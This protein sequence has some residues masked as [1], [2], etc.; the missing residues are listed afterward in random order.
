M[1]PLSILAVPPSSDG[2][3]VP[4][5]ADIVDPNTAQGPLNGSFDDQIKLIRAIAT[6]NGKASIYLTLNRL[7]H[8]SHA[9]AMDCRA[10]K[11]KEIAKAS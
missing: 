3:A 4:V 10:G 9:Q 2:R 1:N 7:R 11:P 5:R 6:L 8:Q